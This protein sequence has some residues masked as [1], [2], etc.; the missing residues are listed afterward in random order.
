[1]LIRHVVVTVV[2]LADSA[3]LGDVPGSATTACVKSGGVNLRGVLVGLF[4]LSSLE[5]S[6]QKGLSP[7]A[8]R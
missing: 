8:R 4:G 2:A 1:M 3:F 6:G 5:A 7:V